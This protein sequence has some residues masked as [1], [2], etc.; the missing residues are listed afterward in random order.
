MYMI[1]CCACD[2][3]AVSST[4]FSSLVSL[5]AL[6]IHTIIDIHIS[7]RTEQTNEKTKNEHIDANTKCKHASD[8]PYFPQTLFQ[9]LP[10]FG[11]YR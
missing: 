8:F 10:D 9:S 5:Y 7:M 11:K 2:T 6:R 3:A 4:T 1:M